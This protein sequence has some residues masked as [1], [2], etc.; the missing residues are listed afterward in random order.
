MKLSWDYYSQ[1]LQ[2]AMLQRV[3]LLLPMQMHTPSRAKYY[4][5]YMEK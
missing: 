1:F 4:S 5:Q 2:F 3:R